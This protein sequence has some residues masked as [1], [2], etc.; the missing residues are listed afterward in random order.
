MKNKGGLLEDLKNLN[1]INMGALLSI[2]IMKNR[3]KIE[4]ISKEVIENVC[5]KKN[6][7]KFALIIRN[8]SYERKLDKRV[9]FLRQFH[10]MHTNSER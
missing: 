6:K 1:K 9:R 3:T 10:S 7:R 8:S 5:Y 4:I 2:S